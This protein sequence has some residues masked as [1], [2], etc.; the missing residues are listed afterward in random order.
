MAGNTTSTW[1]RTIDI[2]RIGTHHHSDSPLGF[3]TERAINSRRTLTRTRHYSLAVRMV[4]VRRGSNGH[5]FG[6][7]TAVYEERLCTGPN[8]CALARK[9]S[10]ESF[11]VE[12]LTR[13]IY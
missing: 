6:L 10:D 4:S 8:Q 5:L 7:A 12:H 13:P 1:R 9:R 3:V 2:R 11:Q